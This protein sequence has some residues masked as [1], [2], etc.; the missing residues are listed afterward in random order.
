MRKFLFEDKSTSSNADFTLLELAQVT[1]WS[2]DEFNAV[3]D[4]DLNESKAFDR[5][6]LVV[7]RIS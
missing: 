6:N 7:T 3:D 1:D 4:L 5:G 2:E